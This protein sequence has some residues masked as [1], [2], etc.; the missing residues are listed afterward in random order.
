VRKKGAQGLNMVP[1]Q[2]LLRARDAQH[3]GQS[4][5]F[6]TRGLPSC[7]GEVI[8]ATSCIVPAFA[9]RRDFGGE[10]RLGQR[11]DRAV[12]RSGAQASAPAGL[13]F[14]TP[15]D[16]VAVK[17]VIIT[18]ATARFAWIHAT[19]TGGKGRAG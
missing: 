13:F 18:G 2:N 16:F 7:G 4:L 1:P 15:H 12:Q 3:I 9:A 5:G 10:S 11:L 6:I 8:V 14:D 19:P 17:I